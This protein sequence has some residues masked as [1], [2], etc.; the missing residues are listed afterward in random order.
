MRL[1]HR[2]AA[3]LVVSGFFI[4]LAAA[5]G[6]G[7]NATRQ[8][9][10]LGTAG[11]GQGAGGSGGSSG[12]LSTGQGGETLPSGSGG[13]QQGVGGGCAGVNKSAEKA[14][15]DMYIMFDQSGSMGDATQ[16]GTKW[17]A[18]S[19]GLSQFVQQPEAAGI[20]VGI[21]YFPL[22]SGI[23]CAA[24]PFC[25]T[26]ADCGADPACGPCMLLGPVGV[27]PNALGDSCEAADYA[28]PEVEIAPLPGNVNAILQSIA[29]HGPSGG[30]PTHPA[31]Q[32]AVQHATDWATAN[33]DHVTVVVFATDGEPSGCNEDLGAINALAAAGANGTP[34]I[35]TFV[36]GVGANLGAL[37]GIAAAGGTGQAF[38]IDQN[39]NVQ[40]AFLDAL[41]AIQGQALPCSYVIPEPAGGET[42]N[43]D[44]VNVSYTPGG[45]MPQTIPKV[46]SAADCLPGKLAWY[47]DDNLN[48]TQIVLC[49]DA[50]TTISA[51]TMGSVDIVLG[52]ETI[53]E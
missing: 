28:A 18:V 27:C 17:Q 20:G 48:P 29:G 5:A 39:P 30:T 52:C 13:M 38:L 21:Q 23:Q 2:W 16:G 40:Q 19:N 14:Q 45:G 53:A 49:P 50:C 33:P 7:C 32:G 43:F 8:T 35:L 15:L 51:D 36:I 42:I 44:L 22:S 1:R 34:K 4:A 25:S 6:A 24:V 12:V 9:S 41:N 31:L 26:D 37:N 46:G 10:S 3:E 47:Y 11:S